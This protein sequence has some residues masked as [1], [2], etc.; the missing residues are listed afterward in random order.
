MSIWKLPASMV[1][2]TENY[3]L[4]DSQLSRGRI[5]DTVSVLNN[6]RRWVVQHLPSGLIRRLRRILKPYVLTREYKSRLHHYVSAADGKYAHDAESELALL[7]MYTHIV[8]KGLH[9][10]DWTPGH[11]RA[12]YAKARTLLQK[13]RSLGGPTIAW[14]CDVLEEYDAR[15]ESGKADTELGTPPEPAV[16][17]AEELLAQMKRRSSCR[18]YEDRPIAPAVMNRLVEAALQAPWS[19]S[20][21]ALRVYATVDPTKAED[22]LRCF[23][24]FTSFSHAAGAIVFAVDLRP[25]SMPKELF[26]PHL[27]AG[28]AAS[29]AA[30]M[31]SSIGLSLTFLSW[32]SRSDAGEKTL[33]KIV[34]L[35]EYY[36]IV[37]GVS[38]GYPLRIPVRP[39]RKSVDQCLCWISGKNRPS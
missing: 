34:S 26:V 36:D 18:Q 28:L 2:S 23:K 37:V 32:G 8:D 30:L 14:A 15:Q 38:C 9:R 24:G 19:C 7:R 17:G 25:Y 12:M 39:A 10:I 6:M 5:E 29:C 3:S 21:Q 13:H 1:V 4:L 20:R 35:P 11:S 22:V 16:V 27:D 31:A 33:R